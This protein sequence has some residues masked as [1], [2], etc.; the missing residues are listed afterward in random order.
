M[1]NRSSAKAEA[2]LTISLD[3]PIDHNMILLSDPMSSSH[4]LQ[5]VLRIPEDE[6]KQLAA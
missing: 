5:I 1:A 4:R 2:N 3:I 6:N